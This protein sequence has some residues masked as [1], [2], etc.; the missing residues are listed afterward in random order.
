[1]VNIGMTYGGYVC[2]NELASETFEVTT[3]VLLGASSIFGAIS[4]GHLLER[5]K[6]KTIKILNVVSLLA[7]LLSAIQNYYTYA[8]CVF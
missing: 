2:L 1:M 6:K 7:L 5:E 8:A 4:A 3:L